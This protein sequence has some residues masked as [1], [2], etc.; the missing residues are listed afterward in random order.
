MENTLNFEPFKGSGSRLETYYIGITGSGTVSLYSG[1]YQKEKLDESIIKVMLFFDKEKKLLGISFKVKDLD[2]KG[3]F[4]LNHSKNKKNAW[5]AARNFFTHYEL[6][7]ADYKGKY[8]P[9][10]HNSEQW[11]KIYFIDL[12]E[13]I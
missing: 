1:F 2:E 13:K 8:K 3:I 10:I 9:Q 12:N 5:I 4:S 7:P 6:K 11:G